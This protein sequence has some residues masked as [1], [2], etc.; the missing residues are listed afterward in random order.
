MKYKTFL[1]IIVLFFLWGAC[2]PADDTPGV[3][4]SP[5][6][7]APLSFT[8]NTKAWYPYAGTEVLIF[9]N[10]AGDT[11]RFRRNEPFDSIFTF[12]YDED[13]KLQ[14][15]GCPDSILVRYD[16]P[17]KIGLFE[18]DSL[19]FFIYADIRVAPIEGLFPPAFFEG[20]RVNVGEYLGNNSSRLLAEMSFITDNEEQLCAF[21]AGACEEYELLESVTLLGKTY[22]DVYFK[23]GSGDAVDVYYHL[24]M[25]VVGFGTN[26]NAYWG[27]VGE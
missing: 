16:Y 23:V 7:V 27:L 8:E 13:Y 19:D 10:E 17:T 20:L 1:P 25:G 3:D 15:S 21:D 22:E 18:S 6:N 11:I 2:N 9:K 24:T 4:C 26:S 5:I 12:R 14:R